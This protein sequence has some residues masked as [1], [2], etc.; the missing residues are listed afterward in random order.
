MTDAARVTISCSHPAQL[1]LT[2]AAARRGG[3]T[4]AGARLRVNDEL[5]HLAGR[6]GRRGQRSGH[7]RA[8][9]A[10][11]EKCRASNEDFTITERAPIRAFPD[12]KFGRLRKDHSRRASQ[13][14][15]FL[16]IGRGLLSDCDIFANLRLQL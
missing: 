2:S 14:N 4:A 3:V 13:F 6:S 11:A 1:T 8:F 7:T 16:V 9:P 12:L 10:H 15:I 5:L